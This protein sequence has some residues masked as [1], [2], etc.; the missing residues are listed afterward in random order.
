MQQTNICFLLREGEI[1]LAMKKRGFGA[2]KWNG[3][4]GKCE[5]G[6]TPLYSAIREVREE[7]CVEV[8]EQDMRFV[9]LLHFHFPH[10]PEWDQECSV[11]LA[12]RFIGEPCETEEMRPQW[13]LC[14]DIPY[15]SMWAD[16]V[17]WLPQV[18]AGDVVDAR[19]VLNEDNSVRESH[20]KSR[21]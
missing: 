19:F 6:E 20:I 5:E 4:G 13:F 18:L 1:L 15:A 21:K 7:I 8:R 17:L 3:A 16:D 11:F 10:K 2:G 14:K 12:D 9:A